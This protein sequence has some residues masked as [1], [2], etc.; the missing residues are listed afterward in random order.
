M[1][2]IKKIRAK[3]EEF[4]GQKKYIESTI[5]TYEKQLVLEQ[6]N[7]GDCANAREVIRTVSQMTQDQLSFHLEDIVSNALEAV[8]DQPYKFK[9][10]FEKQRN[11]TECI[12]RL[13]DKNGNLVSPLDASGGG[14]VDICSFAL[15]IAIWSIS[16]PR[17]RP[18]LV[19]DEPFRYLSRD[20]LDNAVEM[21]SELCEKLGLQV[22]MV[23]HERPLVDK[24]DKVFL[25]K[26]NSQ[27]ESEVNV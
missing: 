21:L 25:I 10:E 9:V 17:T 8:F 5:T 27:G 4:R 7:L 3:V 12:L 24:A 1:N 20:L 15:R 11:K 13:E 18:V 19:L 23:S 22:I 16:A 26:K 6:E 14:V 2:D